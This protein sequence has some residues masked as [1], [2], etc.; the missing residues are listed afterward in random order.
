MSNVGHIPAIAGTDT[1]TIDDLTMFALV[2]GVDLV[3]VSQT[4]GERLTLNVIHA[5]PEARRGLADAVARDVPAGLAALTP[6][7]EDR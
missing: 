7:P 4:Y 5:V 2:P 3:Q 1:I 6:A